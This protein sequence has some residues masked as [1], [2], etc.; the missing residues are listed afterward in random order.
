MKHPSFTAVVLDKH[1]E[2]VASGSAW[3][4]ARP[5]ESTMFFTHLRID[6]IHV[7]ADY[8]KYEYWKGLIGKTIHTNNIEDEVFIA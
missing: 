6:K 5:T 4:E 3:S 7:A 8:P 1:H 2:M